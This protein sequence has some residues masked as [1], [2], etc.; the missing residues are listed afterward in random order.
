MISERLN[1]FLWE[2]GV[3]PNTRRVIDA[4][5]RK[6]TD[7]HAYVVAGAR[8]TG[9]SRVARHLMGLLRTQT[10]VGSLAVQE[11]RREAGKRDVTIT[12]VR[13]LI[14]HLSFRPM[15][16]HRSGGIIH[17][18]QSL[19]YE[20]MNALLKTLEEPHGQPA[21]ILVTTEVSALLPTIRSR[22]WMVRVR[23]I[24]ADRIVAFLQEQG[25][26]ID[27]GRDAAAIALGQTETAVQY[28]EN[29]SRRDDVVQIAT[30]LA[31]CFTAPVSER[32]DTLDEWLPANGRFSDLQERSLHILSIWRS[33]V[34]DILLTQSTASVPLR[35]PMLRTA[36][37]R[38]A[39]RFTRSALLSAARESDSAHHD[40][41]HNV[42]PRLR[43]ESLMLTCT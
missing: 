23:T 1:A 19:T 14:R 2:H 12:Q 15:D 4:H 35:F 31:G 38:I 17:D 8:G 41:V 20:A 27:A 29:P 30:A 21:I 33:T 39:R 32:L 6:G 24:P 34:R 43:L 3:S 11:V 10:T 5:I 28:A 7:G 25:F 42:Q 13:D 22:C 18:A 9:T 36:Y 40:V 16:R 26:P 37:D